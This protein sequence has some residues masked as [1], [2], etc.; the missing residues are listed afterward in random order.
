MRV[1]PPPFPLM[2]EQGARCVHCLQP[3][4]AMPKEA[5]TEDHAPPNSWYRAGAGINRVTVPACTVCNRRLGKLE[6]L[7]GIRFGLCLNRDDP[8]AGEIAQTARRAIAPEYGH[9]ER[10]QHA[11]RNLRNR[12]EA[13]ISEP[14][15]VARSVVPN[16]PA[17]SPN[18]RF[19]PIAPPELASFTEKMVRVLTRHLFEEYIEATHQV[20]IPR[21]PLFDHEL[22]LFMARLGEPQK[23]REHFEETWSAAWE[24][25]PFR[26]WLFRFW[27]RLN[28]AAV[29]GP[30]EAMVGFEG[31]E[32]SPGIIETRLPPA[33]G[34]RSPTQ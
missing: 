33:S 26:I 32:V 27:G 2:E 31:W 11:R 10:D 7:L 14:G 29:T 13:V 8:R 5:Q 15:S 9:N 4:H 30:A 6:E 12:I 21:A 19:I 28:L 20:R 23:C 17:R 3:F 22:D 24:C 1:S 16:F 18:S 34:P 25:G